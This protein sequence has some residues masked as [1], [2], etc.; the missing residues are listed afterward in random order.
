MSRQALSNPKVM[1]GLVKVLVN[2]TD[3]YDLLRVRAGE[4]APVDAA[5][6]D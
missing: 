5:A 6:R 3:L 4:A 2:F 1:E